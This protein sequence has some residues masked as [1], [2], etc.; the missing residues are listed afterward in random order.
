MTLKRPRPLTDGE[1]V[2][3]RTQEAGKNSDK[4]KGVDE[5]WFVLPL[6]DLTKPLLPSPY[7]T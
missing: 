7:L 5:K 4:I 1:P 3:K 2:M 6:P